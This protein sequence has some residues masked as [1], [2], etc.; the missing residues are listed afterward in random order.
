MLAKGGVAVPE[1]VSLELPKYLNGRG[2]KGLNFKANQMVK[3]P[4]NLQG[5]FT[6]TP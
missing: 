1:K 5:N 3:D 6:E 4:Y 2:K